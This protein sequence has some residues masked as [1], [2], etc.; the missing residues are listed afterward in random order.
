MENAD[1]QTPLRADAAV[2][3]TSS[4]QLPSTAKQKNDPI[5]TAKELEEMIDQ[6]LLQTTNDTNIED[7]PEDL[8][9]LPAPPASERKHKIGTYGT[10]SEIPTSSS[11][12]E[13]RKSKES[14]EG[15]ELIRTLSEEGTELETIQDFDEDE[16]PL[17]NG[18][19]FPQKMDP[20]LN[21]K[22]MWRVGYRAFS[23]HI[24]KSI[25]NGATFYRVH[26]VVFI[27]IAWMG[28]LMIYGI[29]NIDYTGFIFVFCFVDWNLS[30]LQSLFEIKKK[31]MRC[32]WLLQLLRSQVYQ[33]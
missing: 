27:L 9:S 21:W 17:L 28:S 18:S 26:L 1:E 15:F 13:A 5:K 8:V 25:L 30:F 29:E 14:E 4:M 33:Q 10:T 11:R 6:Y 19:L 2:R 23:F 32:L 24:V 31:Q 20:K 12:K 16:Q 3:T 22:D 7:Y